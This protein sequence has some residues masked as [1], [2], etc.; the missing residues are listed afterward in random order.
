MLSLSFETA[1]SAVG[2]CL[3]TEMGP[4]AS[5]ELL[6]GR[7]HAESLLPAT[8]MLLQQLGR[9][10]H[11]LT[12]LAVDIGPGLFTGLRVAVAT[13]KALA[14][15]TELP[16]Y[17][18]SSLELLAAE[19]LLRGEIGPGD[20]VVALIDARRGELYAARFFVD[21]SGVIGEEIPASVGPAADVASR[22]LVDTATLVVGDTATLSRRRIGSC[23]RPMSTT[24]AALL[25]LAPG[26]ASRMPSSTIT[27]VD[28]IELLYLRAPDAE[29]PKAALPK[30][31]P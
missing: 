20:S 7:R 17:S 21:A 8:E 13:V 25:A 16:V 22:C 18:F 11:E 15:V 4:A 6:A 29:L 30:A 1:T 19:A 27:E 10:R 23:T 12:H 28:A 2:V 9:S 31:A 5:F 24:M 3:G 26:G 14:L